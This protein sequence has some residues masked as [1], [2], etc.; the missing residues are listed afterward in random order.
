MTR[1]HPVRGGRISTNLV[2]IL[3]D[4]GATMLRLVCGDAEGARE[5]SGV[6]IHDPLDAP[7]LPAGALVLGIGVH[8]PGQI[9]RLLD[10]LGGLDAAVLVVRAPVPADRT[11]IETARR[12]GVVLLELT[13]GASWT[14]LATWLRTLLAADRTGDPEPETLG[15]IPSGDLF[16]LANAIAALL[17]APVTIEDRDSRVLAFSGGQDAADRSRTETIL[18][19]QVP[20]LYSETLE[21]KGIFRELYRSESPVRIE[22]LPGLDGFI[23]PRIAQTVRAGDE[24]LGTIWAATDAPLTPE[25]IHAFE[26]VGKL[27]AVH[28]L[29]QRAGSDVARRM[30][31]DLLS[32]AVDGGPHAADALRKLGVA[33]RPVTVLAMV[34][35]RGRVDGI[36]TAA[37]RA[38]EHERLADAFAMHLNA[39][40]PTV[41]TALLGETGYAIVPVLGADRAAEA[42]RDFVT[43][44]GDRAP[45]LIGIGT[46]A[47]D[48]ADLRRSRD[49]ADR[50]L[51]VLRSGTVSRR[52][53]DISDV[54]TEALLLELHDLMALRRDRLSGPIAHLRDYD[55]A[56]GSCL[57]AT[58]RAWLDAFGDVNAAA[59]AVYIHPNTFRYRLRRIGEVGGIDLSDP[60][61]RFG[62]LLQLKLMALG[63]G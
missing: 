51:R 31:A 30:R 17:D 29:R 34:Q 61:A 32:R 36:D 62:A 50:A 58:L 16:A 35:D 7:V 26:E 49:D 18:G 42:A 2:R 59:A 60:D 8:G 46:V 28:L 52:V 12:T 13:R 41:A 5:I 39:V 55:A 22:P 48:V 24:V 33:D 20:E 11:L 45:V 10:D 6:V 4:L 19:R 63:D 38:S 47:A 53:A 27:A 44:V 3:D 1:P 57:L 43:R 21:A 25:R 37:R 23:M 40:Y 54:Q 14:Q 15:G 56:Q 9:G